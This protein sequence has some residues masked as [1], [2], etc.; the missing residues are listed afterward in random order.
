MSEIKNQKSKIKD[1]IYDVIIIGGGPAGLTAGLYASRAKLKTL[2]LEKQ[3]PG[4]QVLFTDVIENFPG[5]SE[6][7]AGID[8]IDEMVKQAKGFGLEIAGGEA[9]KIRHDHQNGHRFTIECASDSSYQTLSVI[10]APGAHWKELGVSG[11]SSFKGKGVSYCATCD[12]PLFK[13]RD[14][15]VVG[16]G[17]KALEE[18]LFLSKFANSVKLIHRRD[19]FRAVKD[20]QYRVAN[21]SKIAPI[22]DSV[23]T[24]IGGRNRV[25][26]VKIL[27]AKT[28]KTDIISCSGVFIFIGI[29]PNSQI[30]K[31]VADL[32]EK[33][34][35]IVDGCMKTSHDGIYACGDAVKKGLYQ[36]VTAVAEGATAAFNANSY[37]EKQK[38]ESYTQ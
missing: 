37:I 29:E 33:G 30:L 1:D 16:G 14:V 13:D 28:K 35:I 20:L 9:I 32:D 5:F 19:R 27:N 34:F 3:T 8:L 21:N 22:L 4:G 38:G 11:E 26:Y 17:D 15:V 7:I 31:G 24:E 10:M 12:G 6:H 25:D 36:I 2:L 18:A 23:I